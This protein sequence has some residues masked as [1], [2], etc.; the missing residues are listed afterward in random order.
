VLCHIGCEN[1]DLLGAEGACSMDGYNEILN[2]K[3]ALQDRLPILTGVAI[4]HSRWYIS[5]GRSGDKEEHQAKN[6]RY[7]RRTD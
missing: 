3:D 7:T 2:D 6:K 1:K 5:G 4:I